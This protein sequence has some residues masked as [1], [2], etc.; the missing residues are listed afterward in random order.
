MVNRVF[1]LLKLCI[2][3]VFIMKTWFQ[4]YCILFR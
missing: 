2:W 4:I 3:S 1:L